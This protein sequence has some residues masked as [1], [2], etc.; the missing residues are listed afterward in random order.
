MGKKSLGGQALSN[1]SNDLPLPFRQLQTIAECAKA[2]RKAVMK[3]DRMVSGKAPGWRGAVMDVV[4]LE[5]QYKTML[6]AITTKG[7]ES[8]LD[9]IRSEPWDQMG[10]LE[11]DTALY[12]PADDGC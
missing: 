5:H 8:T 12:D 7:L 3:L 6:H 9:V 11:I 1:D 4:S 10:L 2:L